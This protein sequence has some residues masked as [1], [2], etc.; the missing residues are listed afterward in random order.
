M[1]VILI[2]LIVTLFFFDY[3]SISGG[4]IDN[5]SIARVNAELSKLRNFPIE[6]I[7]KGGLFVKDEKGYKIDSVICKEQYKYTRPT[8]YGF[9]ATL[10]FLKF[11]LLRAYDD[12]DIDVLL[13]INCMR[14]YS[15][16]CYVF[17]NMASRLLEISDISQFTV[18]KIDK[19][20]NVS[21][22]ELTKT[23]ERAMADPVLLDTLVKFKGE[24]WKLKIE[25]L[26]KQNKI[27]T[28]L[29]RYTEWKEWKGDLLKE[30][31]V[32]PLYENIKDS[33]NLAE[34]YKELYNEAFIERTIGS[35]TTVEIFKE[36]IRFMYN[37]YVWC[38]SLPL[39][40]FPPI[41][42]CRTDH[43][44]ISKWCGSGQIIKNFV[45]TT[46]DLTGNG[47]KFKMFA[48]N[49]LSF[50]TLPRKLRSFYMVAL[51]SYP[52]ESEILL[53]FI[54]LEHWESLNAR[55]LVN[56]RTLST[57]YLGDGETEEAVY[58][59]KPSNGDAKIA[60]VTSFKHPPDNHTFMRSK[61]R[62]I[63]YTSGGDSRRVNVDDTI[64]ILKLIVMNP[65]HQNITSILR[66]INRM[67][68]Y[69]DKK[70]VES[71]TAQLINDI[72]RSNSSRR[73]SSNTSY[74]RSRFM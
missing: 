18:D 32:K 34:T 30:P 46:Y 41:I 12:E 74:Y 39:D 17:I 55:N 70:Y 56:Y 68:T 51:S 65:I 40:T 15:T 60:I 58:P 8:G 43:G 47:P 1:I 35:M 50:I 4:V 61:G 9:K 49:Y 5:T 72:E 36:M 63:R 37:Y 64:L 16:D 71:Y 22:D 62:L 23:E 53:P 48:G 7:T 25:S 21:M 52:D 2:V 42:V 38:G 3:F 67:S 66:E 73:K 44:D 27:R 24:D 26:I 69:L 59:I 29:N 54:E 45:S 6:K 31:E 10:N 11:K 33:T 20:F 28:P 19:Q 14:C 57:G 13:G